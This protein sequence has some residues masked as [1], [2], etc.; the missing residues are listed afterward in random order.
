MKPESSDQ[1]IEHLYRQRQSRIKVPEID[2]ER[3]TS[4]KTQVSLPKS[5]LMISLGG[6]FASFAIMAL[7][8][9]LAKPTHDLTTYTEPE[10]YVEVSVH[11]P[12]AD[13]P[14]LI[15]T[16]LPPEP[17]MPELPPQ[18]GSQKVLQSRVD[19]SEF[20]VIIPKDLKQEISQQVLSSPKLS[21]QPIY[22][23]LPKF[24]RQEITKRDFGFVKLAY[25]V[26][27]Q[28]EVYDINVIEASA[29]KSLIR[30]SKK[31][32]AQWQYSKGVVNHNEMEIV[33][34]FEE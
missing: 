24:D 12:E 33:F 9:H 21:F 34:S 31:A 29:S 11:S 16:T 15:A 28:G 6:G 14:T 18:Q 5:L 26:N 25:H 19:V 23:V 30:A 17:K 10:R 1:E 8:Q 4:K 3:L 27:Q 13:A 22:R 20:R 32:L 7:V 2:V